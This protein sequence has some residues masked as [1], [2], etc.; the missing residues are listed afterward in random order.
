MIFV[1]FFFF[2]R[3]ARLDRFFITLGAWGSAV[4]AALAAAAL[5][6]ALGGAASIAARALA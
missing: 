6:A 3:L 2:V 5:A 4:A 1:I